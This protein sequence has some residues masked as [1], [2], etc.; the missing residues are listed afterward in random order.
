MKKIKVTNH[1]VLI[2]GSVARRRLVRQTLV[3]MEL[4]SRLKELQAIMNLELEIEQL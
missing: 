3:V 1:Y 2:R 4:R